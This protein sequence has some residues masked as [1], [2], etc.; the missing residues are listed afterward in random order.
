MLYCKIK[1][2]NS[3]IACADINAPSTNLIE[4]IFF[5]SM[6]C[7]VFLVWSEIIAMLSYPAIILFLFG[8]GAY[9]F[10]IIFYILGEIRPI[11]HTVWHL[12]VIAGAAFHWFDVYFFIIRTDIG[13]AALAAAV[14]K[15]DEYHIPHGQLNTTNHFNSTYDL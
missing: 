15:M 8:G 2:F 11:Y 6:G 7:G 9:L 13:A 1:I 3:V 4:L 5:I 12:F 14:A 10:G